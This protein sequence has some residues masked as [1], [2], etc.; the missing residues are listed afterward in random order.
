[1]TKLKTDTDVT[2]GIIKVFEGF[3]GAAYKDATGSGTIGYGHLLRKQDQDLANRTISEEEASTLLR[4]D[5]DAH[6]AGAIK[7]LKKKVN[8]NQMAALASLA[9]NEGAY[10]VG[11]TKIVGLIN[12]G[13][14]DRDVAQHFLGINKSKGVRLEAL[15]QRREIEATLFLTAEGGTVDLSSYGSKKKAASSLAE[16]VQEAP[17]VAVEPKLPEEISPALETVQLTKTPESSPPGKV[18]PKKSMG[19]VSRMWMKLRTVIG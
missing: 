19:L 6:K 18:L 10:G 4:E 7:G 12:S 1:M 9:F 3:R 8:K 11:L 14:D 5:I 13:A 2:E 16:V 17:L 15:A